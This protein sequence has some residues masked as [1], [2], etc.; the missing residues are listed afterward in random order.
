[1]PG[2]SLFTGAGTGFSV[3]SGEYVLDIRSDRV[4]TV[5]IL[6]TD[7]EA[8]RGPWAPKARAPRISTTPTM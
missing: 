5:T 4:W 3:P 7:G 8:D 1:M 2:E 6:T